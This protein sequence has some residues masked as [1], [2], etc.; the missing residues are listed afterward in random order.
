MSARGALTMPELPEVETVR[1]GLEPVMEG[2]RFDKVEARRG[3]LRWPLPK[4]F[5]ARLEGQT[6]R[7]LGRRAKY[8][9]AD[10]SSGD[11]LLMHL[12]MSGSFRV[13]QG[14][15]GKTPGQF[16]HPRSEDRAH[17]HV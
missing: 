8:L 17:D 7:G 16:H 6:V 14:N 1:R 15:A 11:V 13:L 10:L 2:A 12:G 4:D 9:L 3:D 5:V